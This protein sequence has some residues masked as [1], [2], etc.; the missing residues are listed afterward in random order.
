MASKSS[1]TTIDDITVIPEPSTGLLVCLGLAGL[2][3]MKG[4]GVH[5]RASRVGRIGPRRFGE[6]VAPALLSSCAALP[7]VTQAFA[8]ARVR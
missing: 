3:A 7:T 2:G 5:V 4:D 8:L 6:G 1:R